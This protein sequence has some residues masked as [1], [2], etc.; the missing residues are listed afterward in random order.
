[1]RVLELDNFA[2]ICAV[3]HAIHDIVSGLIELPAARVTRASWDPI[4]LFCLAT[5]RKNDNGGGP[6][7]S[8]MLIY[9]AIEPLSQRLNDLEPASWTDVCLG[10]AVVRDAALDK[11]PR[12]RQL[13]PNHATA[14][15]KGVAG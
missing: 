1:M 2:A 13:H 8:K 12:W 3:A 11:R 10:R 7:R 5:R 14:A 15:N 6:L 4:I 9:F